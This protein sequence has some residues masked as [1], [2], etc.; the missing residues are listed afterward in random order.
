MLFGLIEIVLFLGG[1]AFCIFLPVFA[2]I[3]IV[4]SNF[5]GSNKLIWVVVVV[6][7]NFLG[8]ILYFLIGRNQK[9]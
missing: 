5:E 9:I 4:R 1:L 7:L 8:A 3:D 2:L 6:G